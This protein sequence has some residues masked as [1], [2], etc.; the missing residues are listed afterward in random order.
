[1]K[2]PIHQNNASPTHEQIA[3]VAYSLWEQAGRPADRDMEFWTQAESRLKTSSTA[4]SEAASNG[5][6]GAVKRK[7]PTQHKN[8]NADQTGGLAAYQ[9]P[10]PAKRVGSGLAARSR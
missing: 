9:I 3:C 7:T 10:T 2:T 4:V 1:M 6:A 8:N 5:S